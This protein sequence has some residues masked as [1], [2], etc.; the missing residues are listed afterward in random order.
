MKSRLLHAAILFVVSLAAVAVNVDRPITARADPPPNIEINGLDAWQPIY[1]LYQLRNN[2]YSFAGDPPVPIGAANPGARVLVT[3]ELDNYAAD[4][5]APPGV[6]YNP[7]LQVD[8]PS[9]VTVAQADFTPMGS[10]DGF[11]NAHGSSIDYSLPNPDGSHDY[12]SCGLYSGF[13]SDHNSAMCSM[14]NFHNGDYFRLQMGL[15]MPTN[16]DSVVITAYLDPQQQLP[17]LTQVPIV[18]LT[19]PINRPHL[20][21]SFP[22]SS[23][24]PSTVQ[25]GTTFTYTAAVANSGGDTP[26]PVDLQVDLPLELTTASVAASSPASVCTY[27]HPTDLSRHRFV[28]CTFQPLLS[29]STWT[30]T[31]TASAP[32]SP[33]TIVATAT[34]D[35][36]GAVSQSTR[37]DDVATIS[38]EVVSDTTA[39]IVIGTPDRAADSNGWYNHALVVTWTGLDPDNAPSSL[40]CDPATPYGGRDRAVVVL[41]GN[42]ADPAGN[43]GSG[44]FGFKYDG[45][46]P[47]IAC[48]S[49]D[50]AWHGSDV[51][52]ACTASDAGSGLANAADA[53]FTLMTTVPGGTGTADASTNSHQVC[54]VANNC[55][56]A[57]P[58][59]RIMVDKTAPT[60]TYV[61]RTVPNA[62][63]WNDTNVTLNWT[64]ADSLSG[65]VSSTV[66]QIISTEGTNQS[67]TGTCTGNTGNSA[68]DT[69]G[70]V[71]IDKTAPTITYAGRTT[72][73]AA[74][75]NN[76][77]VT[78]TWTCADS[79][80]GPVS[81][82]VSQTISTEGANESATGTCTDNAGNSAGD[83]QVDVNIDKTAPPITYSGRTAPNAAGWNNTN[84]TLNWTCADSLSG[85]V[86]G[87]VSQ[88]IS[89]EGANQSATGTCTDNAGNS[90]GDTQGGVNID[91][92]PPAITVTSPTAASYYLNQVVAASYSCL[93]TLSGVAACTG[94]VA[95][96]A[97]FDTESLGNKTFTVNAGDVAGNQASITVNYVVTYRICALFDQFAVHQSG[98]TIPIKLQLCDAAG[99]DLSSS[100]TVVTAVMLRRVSTSVTGTPV[101]SGNANP[102]SNFR[103][104]SSL[105]PTG[106]YIYNLSTKGLASGSY[107]LSFVVSGDPATHTV[108]FE[109]R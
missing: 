2:L 63:G 86:S 18:T 69:Q 6:S 40:T 60:I 52:I 35:P 98:S 39:P 20:V 8:I 100:G 87:S 12:M 58:I 109:I 5:I 93:D 73:N 89:T 22:D 36:N 37:A 76:T 72:P 13:F 24:P 15:T 62:A 43:L 101:A 94:T 91:K 108:G 44:I 105:G 30:V 41:I 33:G 42:C 66:S 26:G 11:N 88:T 102:D 57:G 70:G 81:G 84:V 29:G 10:G 45:T 53:N 34:A 71:N 59:S 51:T 67:A 56:T 46:P 82:S 103:F 21:A 104:D 83:T 25:A 95:N 14:V 27:Y 3:I 47:S 31:I 97:N 23:S 85:P 64:C 99:T 49:A 77:N 106:G 107:Q 1:S 17:Q 50:T 32:Q 54:D 28:Y 65:S 92:T 61:G 19:I 9:N 96:L 55:V 78:L 90:A 7:I 74:G 68:S 48:G 80:S 79:L 4:L 16:Q 75:W 38:V